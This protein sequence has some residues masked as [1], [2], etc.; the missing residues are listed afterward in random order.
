MSKSSSNT[1]VKRGRPTKLNPEVVTKLVAAFNMAYNDT[2]A[3]SYAGISRKVLYEW[4]RYKDDFRDKINRAKIEPTIKAKEVV[5]NAV[6]SGDLSAAKWWLERKAASEFNTKPDDS[7]KVPAEL[8]EYIDR[9][10]GIISLHEKR[11]AYHYRDVI[12]RLREQERLKQE[13]SRNSGKMTLKDTVLSNLLE[14]PDDKLADH[15]AQEVTATGQDIAGVR[16]ILE[17]RLEFQSIYRKELERA[18]EWND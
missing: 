3:A 8:A 10:R 7:P 2:E 5:V 4:L 11:I 9:I 15:V 13:K 6:N 1:K 14:L 16:R 18:K 17:E 12:Y